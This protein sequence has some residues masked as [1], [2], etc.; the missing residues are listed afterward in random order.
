MNKIQH[1]LGNK[2]GDYNVSFKDKNGTTR[3]AAFTG[4]FANLPA[5]STALAD[6]HKSKEFTFGD[7]ETG[8]VEWTGVEAAAAAKCLHD[9][10]TV[11]GKAREKLAGGANPA[12]VELWLRKEMAAYWPGRAVNVA[13][14]VKM[15]GAKLAAFYAVGDVAGAEQYMREC[16]VVVTTAPAPSDP[17]AAE[18]A[19]LA[20]EVD[21]RLASLSSDQLAALEEAVDV[22]DG[23]YE[24]N[25]ESVQ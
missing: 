22:E 8:K 2:D 16:G 9:L 13:E 25:A 19:R 18:A 14:P 1:N 20:A 6:W 7:A 4:V 17:I 10:E 21:A 3:K 23:D 5:D 11:R 12:S 24:E 15:D